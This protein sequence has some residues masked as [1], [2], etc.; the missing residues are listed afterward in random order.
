MTQ[1]QKDI[2]QA[3]RDAYPHETW[4]FIDGA[5]WSDQNPSVDTI[6]KIISIYKKWYSEQS[7]L[8]IIDYI[9]KHYKDKD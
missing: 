2:A 3:A 8:S 7:D 9:Q 4:I 1:R 6:N 5:M